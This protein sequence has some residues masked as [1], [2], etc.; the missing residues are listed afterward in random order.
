M[1]A[2]PSGAGLA[3]L[4]VLVVV[5]HVR[6]VILRLDLGEPQVGVVAVGLANSAGVIV[7]IEEVDV[8]AR[9]V[10]LESL[11]ESPGPPGLVR[12]DRVVLVR[13][14]CGVDD[15]AKSTGRRNTPST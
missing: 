2:V 14:P 9:A 5:E 7:G 8:D 4:D 15:E 3:G 11:E 10:G 6:G 13:E 12:A 1:A